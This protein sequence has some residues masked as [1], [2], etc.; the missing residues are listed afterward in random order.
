MNNLKPL[1]QQHVIDGSFALSTI[2]D[3]VTGADELFSEMPDLK[4]VVIN[5]TSVRKVRNRVL[6]VGETALLN[7]GAVK[8]RATFSADENAVNVILIFELPDDWQFASSLTELPSVLDLLTFESPRLLVNSKHAENDRVHFSATLKNRDI[9]GQ[10]SAFF[11]A[12]KYEIS[13]PLSI[14]DDAFE[15]RLYIAHKKAKSFGHLKITLF[16]LELVAVLQRG[17]ALGQPRLQAAV[18]LLTQIKAGQR[19]P[20]LTFE[21]AYRGSSDVQLS[22]SSTDTLDLTRLSAFFGKFD[23]L[24]QLPESIQTNSA[25]LQIRDLSLQ[26]DLGR[27]TIRELG[28]TAGL[29]QWQATP[30]IEI[31]DISIRLRVLSPLL[32]QRSVDGFISGTL[33]VGRTMLRVSTPLIEPLFDFQFPDLETIKVSALSQALM[34]G[35]QA[36]L[37]MLPD[38]RLEEIT[39]VLDPS[40][41]KL[42]IGAGVVGDWE[43]IPKILTLEY[44][45]IDLELGAGAH[46]TVAA[47]LELFGSR[48]LV[49]GTID[50][51]LV[52]HTNFENISL[53]Q[54]S[55]T[56]QKT[57]SFPVPLPD[58]SCAMDL[59][60]RA[61]DKEYDF[62]GSTSGTWEIDIGVGG[63][64]MTNLVIA[65]R[66]TKR[67]ARRWDTG[68]EVSGQ[69]KIGDVE[70]DATASLGKSMSLSAYTPEIGLSALLN[71]L[72][73][74]AFRDL[75]ALPSLTALRLKRA[76]IDVDMAAKSVSVKAT[77]T[78]GGFR[79]IAK[80]VG[81]KWAFAG[82]ILPSS[83]FK[84]KT[85]ANELAVLDSLNFSNS[86]IILA[87][88]PGLISDLPDLPVDI[89]RPSAGLSLATDL[90]TRGLGI[91]K[92][93]GIDVLAVA[94]DLSADPR[95]IE[96]VAMIDGEMVLDDKL[97]FTDLNLALRPSPSAPSVT[98]SGT[99]VA[100]INQQPLNFIG[101]MEVRPRALE[102]QATM[103]GTWDN[104]FGQKGLSIS[105]V[106]LELGMSFPPP[107]PVVGIAGQF[108][109]GD[110]Y[111]SAAVR[112]DAGPPPK[113]M[114]AIAFTQLRL[115]DVIDT[116]TSTA[117]QRSIPASMRNNLLDIAMENV[118]IFVVPE[119]T[120]I[121]D[122]KF[123]QGTSLKGTIY[124][125]GY[126]ALADMRIDHQTGIDIKASM[127]PLSLADGVLKVSGSQGRRRPNFEVSITSGKA[128]VIEING[129]I[130]IL[131]IRRESIIQFSPSGFRFYMEGSLFGLFSASI[132]VK[133]KDFNKGGDFA[134]TAV[135]QNDL[136]AYLRD[137]ATR[138]IQDASEEAVRAIAD[139]QQAINDAQADI[140]RL[141]H[142]IQNARSTVNAER[143]RDRRRLLEAEQTVARERRKASELNT[144]VYQQRRVVTRERK[145]ITAEL[146]KAQASVKS[147]QRKVKKLTRDLAR[148]RQRVKSE[149][150]RDSRR[151]KS[152]R[153]AVSKA[154]A[155]VKSLNS[156]ISKSK[157]RIRTLKDNIK[158]KKRWYNKL[159][160]Y[161]QSWGWAELAAYSAR[162]GVEIAAEYTKIGGLESAKATANGV[163]EVAKQALREL[164]RSIK[165]FPIDADPRVA[166]LIT[167]KHTATALL[168]AARSVVRKIEQGVK[169]M[170]IDADPRVAGPL[171]GL[172]IARAALIAGEKILAG[173]RTAAAGIPV[174]ADPRVAGLIAAQAIAKEAAKAA[175]SVL[176][177]VKET[178][179]G[180]ATIGQ[181]IVE[182]GLGGLLDIKRAKFE[183]QLMAIQ[184]GSVELELELSFLG[185]PA[186]TFGLEFNF[187]DPAKAVES[188]VNRLLP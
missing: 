122:L 29:A 36:S 139:A 176:Q 84:L 21:G 167:A 185:G 86:A 168:T 14:Q 20:T 63:L 43:I 75:K 118:E 64:R 45:L 186:E 80:Q 13:G 165:S 1:L 160:W 68:I 114:L 55:Q 131:G 93:L 127:D 183:A 110:F 34:P 121:G 146:K 28:F 82:A 23:P 89:A 76:Q 59:E 87:S 72:C 52:L 117:V 169:R 120:T 130:E 48:V 81:P 188:L 74:E 7:V 40:Q 35:N 70:L 17:D 125:F 174:D 94:A 104:A 178:M 57:P 11:N 38:F 95:K 152:A 109:I 2:T 33:S 171:A 88:H 91:D 39:A 123:E 150:S 49:Q 53:K 106:A 140:N 142:Q 180:L 177:G 62:V 37:E 90:N 60:I 175:K 132:D 69:I 111:G 97:T 12:P 26:L 116:F 27:P 24:K 41:K 184:G 147:A 9:F 44:I 6:L 5:V 157:S 25:K 115:P 161:D 99:L 103:L 50:D 96:L 145:Q 155:S 153:S 46:G 10:A 133:G 8:V 124:F 187:F 126:R 101:G 100:N 159:T 98:I 4:A 15:C 166:G 112:F 61:R 158:R 181:Y 151:V 42:D 162:R 149:R 83:R 54:L 141:D 47:M 77:S 71:D 31:N 66:R 164:E 16:E 179:G 143:A 65:A 129:A 134:V 128:P 18:Y 137:N 107:L 182:A 78:L 3:F 156:A 67:S 172:H 135:M 105:N 51:D 138:A 19:G 56:L 148:M 32:K 170:P 73:G 108:A 58:L 136:L 144:T 173:M 22:I 79:I 163:L 113:S 154:Q 85:L 119:P 30:S 102:F 92:L